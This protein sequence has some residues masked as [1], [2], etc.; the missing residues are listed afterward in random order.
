MAH[1]KRVAV[2]AA[3]TAAT[4]F[5]AAQSGVYTVS[6]AST[7]RTYTVT[8]DTGGDIPLASKHFQYPNLPYHADSGDGPRGTQQG[9]NLCNSTTLGPDSWCQTGFVN[10]IDDFCLWGAPMPNVTVGE[11]EEQLVAYCTTDKWGTRVIPPGALQGVQFIKTPDY[12]EVVGYVDQTKLNLQANDYGGEEDPHGADQR[13]N[14]LGALLYSTAF[15]GS[16]NSSSNTPTQVI[17]WSYFVGS[18]VFCFKACDPAGDRAAELCEHRYDR[19]G[20]TYNAPADYA[21]INGTFSSC[22]GEDQL[23]VGQYISGGRTITWEQPPESLGEITTIPFTPS[24]P[25]TSQCSTYSSDQLYTNMASYYSSNGGDAT[26]SAASSGATSAA[27]SG[28][29]S[30]A[31]AAGSSAVSGARNVNANAAASSSSTTGA[32]GKNVAAAGGLA[33]AALLGAVAFLA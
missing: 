16:G 31:A 10:S 19:V 32:A 12:V 27:S 33:L 1:S 9:Y 3:V 15:G 11:D 17:E 23:P 28:A 26:T 8:Q 30:G 2:A 24:I 5:V 14:P 20:C 21:S 22:Q 18:G 7:T 4:S 13:G 6:D 25:A 29:R